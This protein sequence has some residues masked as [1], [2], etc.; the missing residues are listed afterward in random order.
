MR[1]AAV[2]GCMLCIFVYMLLFLVLSS[3]FII[4]SSS[5]SSSSSSSIII[6][7]ISG[8]SSYVVCI[9]VIVVLMIVC[10]LFVCLLLLVAVTGI[11]V[12]TSFCK[13]GWRVLLSWIPLPRI[14]RPG[15]A[16]LVSIRG[17]ARTTMIYEFELDEGF[18]SYH[19]PF[20]FCS[21][22]GCPEDPSF[23]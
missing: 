23:L 10:L 19:L 12:A 17:S 13:E 9:R 15:S 1:P 4:I 18:Q 11:P 7:I 22:S 20:R 2:T 8:S 3:C 5:S 16:C 14:A 6:I 21:G